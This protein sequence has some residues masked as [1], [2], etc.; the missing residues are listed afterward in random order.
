M[1]FFLL[2][3]VSILLFTAFLLGLFVQ[4][5]VVLNFY[6]HQKQIAVE[7]CI[8]KS[9]PELHCEGHCYL[10]KKLKET[11]TENN[12]KSPKILEEFEVLA[13]LTSYKQELFMMADYSLEK[14][15]IPYTNLYNL[16]NSKDIQHPPQ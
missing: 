9:Q 2:K 15:E 3:I 12:A 11:S 4:S 6:S 1:K 7:K 14:V 5:F 10:N 16:L 8:N 13:I